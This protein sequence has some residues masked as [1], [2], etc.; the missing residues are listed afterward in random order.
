MRDELG[1][2]AHLLWPQ[3]RGVPNSEYDNDTQHHEENRNK[4]NDKL[5]AAREQL[6]IDL[7]Q[8]T[9]L[10]EVSGYNA[11]GE[12]DASAHGV[13]LVS[14]LRWAPRECKPHHL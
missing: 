4:R 7:W 11:G 3:P 12:A 2:G 9:L 14:E 13:R 5:L 10:L 6:G 8:L 1:I